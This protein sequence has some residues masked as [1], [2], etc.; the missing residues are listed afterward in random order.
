MKKTAIL[1]LALCVSLAACRGGNSNTPASTA[2]STSTPT[3]PST[4]APTQPSTSAPTQPS[5][6]APTQPAS[7]STQPTSGDMP[8]ASSAPE[9][10]TPN[11]GMRG[12]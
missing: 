1:A 6:T 8:D 10:G 3:Q 9:G 4:T 11:E 2:P 12:R 7:E 5:T